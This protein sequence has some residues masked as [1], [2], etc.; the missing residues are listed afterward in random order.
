MSDLLDSLLFNDFSQID[1]LPAFLAK[2]GECSGDFDFDLDTG[3]STKLETS[4]IK[5]THKETLGTRYKGP[6][7]SGIVF[8][9]LNFAL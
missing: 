4:K 7:R 1:A 5:H 3:L 6:M 8:Q 9:P 2:H